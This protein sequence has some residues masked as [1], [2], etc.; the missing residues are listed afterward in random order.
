MNV[1]TKLRRRFV[2][3]CVIIVALTLAVV[4][5]SVFGVTRASA[6]ALVSNHLQNEL[7]RVSDPLPTPPDNDT[8]DAESPSVLI[9]K[10]GKSGEIFPSHDSGFSERELAELVSAAQRSKKNTFEYGGRHYRYAAA[11]TEFGV[12]YA[13][14][15]YTTQKTTI[16]A[17]LLTLAILYA[18]CLLFAAGCSWLLS[19]KFVAP[20]KEAMDKQK[21][22]I[23]NASHELKTPLTILSTNL[24]IVTNNPEKTVAE[25]EKWLSVSNAQISKMNELILEM[26]ELSRLDAKEGGISETSDLSSIVEG[27]VLSFEA[28]CYDKNIALTQEITPDLYT[29]GARM[30]LEKAVS[31]IIDN[32]VKYTPYG[33]KITATLIKKSHNAE[34]TV[35]N[36]GDGIAPENIDRIF[37]RFYKADTART[38]SSDK[39]FGLGLA[40]AKSV[41]EHSGGDIICRSV[42]G[43]Y[44]EFVVTLPI[45]RNL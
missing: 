8:A 22:L 39:S 28:S 26:L 19:V 30:Q 4:F 38:E 35:R 14:F 31:T 15:D 42:I 20:V 34:F 29:V 37:D 16:Y 6:D 45:K 3:T 11:E 41:V 27:A 17:L 21:E 10:T 1:Y 12:N 5:G 32:A 18:L 9:I 43:E 2:L 25:N 13:I 23:A 36:T 40:I 44:T 24:D 33:G 7:R